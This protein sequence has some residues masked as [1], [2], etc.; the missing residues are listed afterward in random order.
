[1]CRSAARRR[2]PA[3]TVR[4]QPPDWT[5]PREALA[6]AFSDKTK[7]IVLNSPMNPSAK[8]F[9]AD[10]LAFIADLVQRHDAYAVC[11]EVYEHLVF[12]G[13]KHI[14]LMTLPGMRERCARI[15]SA[16]TRRSRSQA[17]R[18]ATWWRH[19]R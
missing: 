16:G 1:M 18:W 14:P 10:E 17:G 4:I 15:G 11:D 5:L 12:D 13:R 9:D 2:H 3:H 6:A 8:V 19:R 7:L